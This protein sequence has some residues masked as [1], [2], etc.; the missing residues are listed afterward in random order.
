MDLDLA[1]K[2]ENYWNIHPRKFKGNHGLHNYI[3]MQAFVVDIV[4]NTHTH[5]EN[6]KF[7][8]IR[9][10]EEPV[11]RVVLPLTE[12]QME[13]NGLFFK[14]MFPSARPVESWLKDVE[15]G[16]RQ[17]VDTFKRPMQL[18]L[19]KVLKVCLNLVLFQLFCFVNW[20]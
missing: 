9:F 15:G 2:P 7:V 5:T 17:N 6:I 14:K 19:M 18:Q 1:R 11:S 20:F 4:A 16:W 13:T 8:Q 12:A 3:R 10:P